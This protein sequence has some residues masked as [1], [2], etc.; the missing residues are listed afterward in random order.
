M[1]GLAWVSLWKLHKLGGKLVE[2]ALVGWRE[3]NGVVRAEHP[4]T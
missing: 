2:Q 1:L 3:G 4:R